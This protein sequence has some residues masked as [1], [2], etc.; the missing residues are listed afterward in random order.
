MSTGPFGP[1]RR[2]RQ[3]QPE[4]PI[5]QGLTAL[6]TTRSEIILPILAED[7]AA[8]GCTVNGTLDIESELPNAFNAAAQARLESYAALLRPLWTTPPIR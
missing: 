4:L 7:T 8:G 1:V 5:T 6:P 3:R 2:A